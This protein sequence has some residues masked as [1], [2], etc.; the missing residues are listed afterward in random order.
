[1][2]TV[3]DEIKKKVDIIEFIGSFL[4]LKKTGRNFKANCP[5]HQEKTPSFVV[6]PDRQIWH[7]FG[8]CQEGGDI[9][10]FLMKWENITFIEAIKEL[11]GKLGVPLEK[12]RFEDKVWDKKEKLFNLNSLAAEFYQYLLSKTTFGK[13]GL[14]YLQSRDINKKIIEKFQLGYAPQ[15][16][17]SLIKFL[18]KK[19]FSFDEIYEAGL[20]IKGKSNS[21][22]DRFRGRLMFPI[23]DPRGNIIGFSGRILDDKPNE[24]KYINT[25]ETT[26]YHKRETLFGIHLAKDSIKKQ[27]KV[28]LVEGEFDMISPYQY[29]IE[30]IVAIKGSAVTKEQLMLIKRYADRV[31]FALDTDVAG[32]E[33]IKRGIIEAENL[34]FEVDVVTFDYAKDPDEAVRSDEIKFKE[35]ITKPV[36]IYDFLIKIAQQKYNDNTPFNK[37]K[38]GEEVLP[39]IE[40]IS[41]PIVKSHYVKK[42]ADLLSVSEESI[43][44][45]LTRIRRRQ[46]MR[47]FPQY[48]LQVSQTNKNR[49]NIIQKYVLSVLFQSKDPYDFD[50]KLSKNLRSDDFSPLS[51]QRL[52]ELFTSYKNNNDTFILNNFI[53]LLPSELRAVFDEIFL[54]ASSDGDLDNEDINKLIHE[55]K[56]YS[57]KRKISNLLSLEKQD[58]NQLSQLNKELKEVEKVIVSL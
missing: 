21:Y 13:G 9:I 5:F 37:K 50:S 49:E 23:K 43:E 16:W 51:Y 47:R 24:A 18:N 12:T 46:R 26:I 1:M 40:S 27:E 53:K 35:T 19:K 3:I 10:R 6:S 28:I 44:A 30:N 20:S 54:F 33:A 52:L 4:T 57:I 7:C 25:P 38:I 45:E 34:D 39:F 15:S 41:N 48:K 55:I 14:E 56:R 58:N 17:D 22:Y 11:A 36:P 42:I 31:T 29:G 32:I 2:E 8:A